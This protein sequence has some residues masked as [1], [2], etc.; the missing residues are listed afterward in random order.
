MVGRAVVTAHPDEPLRV[1]V[2]RM[3]ET[4]RTRLP[5]V[6]R[7]DARRLLGLVSLGD[8]LKARVLNLEAERR[9]ERV[10]PMHLFFPARAKSRSAE[11]PVNAG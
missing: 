10:H 9:R 2:E 7:D 8:L 11:G 5:V 6:A 4:G 3:A 1:V